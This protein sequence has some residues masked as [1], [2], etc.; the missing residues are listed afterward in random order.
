ME[1]NTPIGI[2]DSGIGGLTLAKAIAEILPNENMVYFGDTAHLPYGDKSATAIQA[3]SMKICNVLLSRNCKVIVIACNSASAA[4]YELVKEYVGS[5][6]KVINVIDPVIE[7][8][9]ELYAGKKIGVIGTR[10]TIGSN[11]YQTKIDLLNK[12]ITLCSLATPLLATMI[13]EGF[14]TSKISKDIIETYISDESLEGIKSLILGCTHYPLIKKDIEEVYKG[15]VKVIDAS[16]I[17]AK[18]LKGYLIDHEL[19]NKE[20]RVRHQF[21]VSDYT[22]SFKNSTQ[23]FF[24]EEVNLELYKLWE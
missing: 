11:V 22:E 13:E 19:E 14:A 21:F 2:F 3:Y 12:N 8:V 20:T 4:A 10:Q 9:K 24:Q 6:A 15:R 23:L 18:S 5:R 17:V 16:A 7:H 1:A